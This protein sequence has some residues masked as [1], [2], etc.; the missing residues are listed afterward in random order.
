MTKQERDDLR[1]ELLKEG[2]APGAA[3]ERELDD[4]EI[5]YDMEDDA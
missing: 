1:N 4:M 2:A 3:L 5:E